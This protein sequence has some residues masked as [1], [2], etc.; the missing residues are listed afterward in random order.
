MEHEAQDLPGLA[1]FHLDADIVVAS[2]VPQGHEVAPQGVPVDLV[3][4]LRKDHGAQCVLRHAAGAA[5]LDGL[6]DVL[7]G[8]RHFDGGGDGRG[9]ERGGL[10]LGRFRF[11]GPGLRL[12]GLGHGPGRFEGV[13]ALGG[14][15]LLS[16]GRTGHEA[17]THQC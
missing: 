3:A 4:S 12:L 11:S 5:K 13:L 17:Q 16:G 8:R 6:D 15:R 10:L 2:G 14:R 1:G 9:L 7:S